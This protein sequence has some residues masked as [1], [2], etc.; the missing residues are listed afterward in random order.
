MGLD[1]TVF[2]KDQE[3]TELSFKLNDKVGL[4]LAYD[5]YSGIYDAERWKLIRNLVK[6][7]GLDDIH[8]RYHFISENTFKAY[9]AN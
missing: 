7:L 5:T 2:Q 9:H 8:R 4:V 1:L 3:F 6:Q